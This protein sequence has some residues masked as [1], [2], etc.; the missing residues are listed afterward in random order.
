VRLKPSS[1]KSQPEVTADHLH[2]RYGISLGFLAGQDFLGVAL[3]QIIQ[4]GLFRNG[5]RHENSAIHFRFRKARPLLCHGFRRERFGLD[6]IA[7]LADF[8]LPLLVAALGDR[9][10]TLFTRLEEVNEKVVSQICP[11]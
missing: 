2:S 5:R 10:Y 11:K 4:C 6:Q 7:P 1:Q 9:C 3:E 8:C